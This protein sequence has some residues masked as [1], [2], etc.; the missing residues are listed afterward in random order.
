MHDNKAIKRLF[1][2]ME[3]NGE[4]YFYMKLQI[5]CM[6]IRVA[7]WCMKKIFFAPDSDSR[8]LIKRERTSSKFLEHC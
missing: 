4:E 7:L 3:I 2:K 8:G 6:N 5:N 1:N